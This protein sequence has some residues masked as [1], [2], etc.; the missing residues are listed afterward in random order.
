MPCIGCI[1]STIVLLKSKKNPIL[2]ETPVVIL[3][4]NQAIWSLNPHAEKFEIII[5]TVSSFVEKSTTSQKLEEGQTFKVRA[6]GDGKRYTNSD[7]SNVVTYTNEEDIYTIIW[8]NGDVVLEID[9]DVAEGII[10]IYDGKIPTKESDAQYQYVF[11]GW[12]LE[13]GVAHADVTYTAVFTSVPNTYIIIWK[14][15]V[16]TQGGI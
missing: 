2:L 14:K 7:W 8:K 4:K 6:I 9:T 3:Q 16:T 13:V 15:W 12:T 10:P 5:N 11:A 1:V